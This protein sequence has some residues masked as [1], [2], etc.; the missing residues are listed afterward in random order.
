MKNN[1]LKLSGSIEKR[2][3]NEGK[4]YEVLM[5]NLTDDYQK[6]VY[7]SR[8]ESQL[9]KLTDKNSIDKNMP[10]FL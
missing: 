6:E 10:S 7:I 5:L 8:A 3:S 4:E 9:L 2:I 1:L